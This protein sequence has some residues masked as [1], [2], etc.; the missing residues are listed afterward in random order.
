MGESR[1]RVGQDASDNWDILS[2]AKGKH[3]F[4]HLTDHP[5]CYVI[6][7]CNEPTEEEKL[8]CARICREHTKQKLSG[9]VK[10]D[11][12]QCSNVKFDRRRDVVGECEYKNEAKVEIL[13]V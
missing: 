12:T 3:W 2:L 4:F 13:T 5:S 1:V 11:V 9:E 10:V 8:E 6:L 7:E